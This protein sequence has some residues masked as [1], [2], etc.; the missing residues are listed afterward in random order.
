MTPHDLPAMPNA[1]SHAFQRDLRG[2]AERPAPEAHAQDDFWSWRTAMFAAAEALDPDRMRA[3]AARVYTEMAA[4]G[5]GAVGEFHYVHH[6]PDG[7]PY[8]DPNA[9]ATT[10]AE[11]AQAAGMRT[12]CRPASRAPS[13]TAWAIALGSAYGVPSGWWWT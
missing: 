1:H 13:A 12:M 9:L 10:V 2:I 11:A 3:V 7:T 8:E 4:A 5:Y 6:R